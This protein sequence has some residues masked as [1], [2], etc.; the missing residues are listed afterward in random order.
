MSFSAAGTELAHDQDAD[1][2]AH[3]QPEQP[4]HQAARLAARRAR[5]ASLS[6]AAASA[7]GLALALPLGRGADAVAEGGDLDQRAAEVAATTLVRAATLL[8]T[9]A[10]L[11]VM[12]STRSRFLFTWATV[13][14]A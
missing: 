10:A 14:L 7:G 13:V 8:E 1:R 11:P 4:P 5:R 3:R 12:S 6:R 9:L 2:D